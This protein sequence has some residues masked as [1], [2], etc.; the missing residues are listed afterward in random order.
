MV[1]NGS[2]GLL[3]LLT[4][5][6]LQYLVGTINPNLLERAVTGEFPFFIAWFYLGVTLIASLMPLLLIKRFWD[7]LTT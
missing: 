2:L 4:L 1:F 5:G 7:F 6:L 3:L